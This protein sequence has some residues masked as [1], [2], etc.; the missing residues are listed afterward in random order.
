VC[1]EED[2]WH[3]A[4]SRVV[5]SFWVWFEAPEL[6]NVKTSILWPRDRKMK[7]NGVGSSAPGLM[8]EAHWSAISLQPR[9]SRR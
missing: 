2:W 1:G 9:V 6:Q 7:N 4:L 8:W 3:A 5:K